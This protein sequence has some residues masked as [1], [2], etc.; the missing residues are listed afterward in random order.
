MAS[1]SCRKVH[2]ELWRRVYLKTDV[3]KSFQLFSCYSRYYFPHHGH[4]PCLCECL[5]YCHYHFHYHCHCHFQCNCHYHY[6]CFFHFI[7]QCHHPSIVLLNFSHCPLGYH[8][9]V[10]LIVSVSVNFIVCPCLCN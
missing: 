5:F 2:R 1:H 7:L 8:C 4:C 3:P 10:T 6:H 9:H